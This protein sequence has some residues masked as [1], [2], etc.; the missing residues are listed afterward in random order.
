MT[1][2][3]RS[4]KMS[5]KRL[6]MGLK[7]SLLKIHHKQ[8]QHWRKSGLGKVFKIHYRYICQYYVVLMIFYPSLNEEKVAKYE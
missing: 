8:W 6:F 7:S 4:D 2:R 5:T 3:P 1:T